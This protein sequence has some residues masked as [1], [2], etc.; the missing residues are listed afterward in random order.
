MANPLAE[1]F[2]R[3]RPMSAGFG[4]EMQSQLDAEGRTA[5]ASG[6]KAGES[7]AAGMK[8]KVSK[9]AKGISEGT[10]GAAVAIGAA[11]IDMA[12]KFQTGLNTLVTSAGESEKNL[13]EAFRTASQRGAILLFDEVDSFLRDR[14]K[15]LH[16]HEAALTNE[17]LQQLDAHAGIIEDAR[18]YEGDALA[19]E[20]RSYLR[21][22]EMLMQET[23]EEEE[24]EGIAHNW[25]E[26][27]KHAI[28]T[29]IR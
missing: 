6:A 27:R 11:S 13:A 3:I 15:A 24:F 29:G 18:P 26:A 2:V 23:T 16:R 25:V 5:G 14:R 4:K 19:S 7:F 12:A 21:Q 10:I 20:A 1:A 9:L 28:R 22:L 17:F 8:S